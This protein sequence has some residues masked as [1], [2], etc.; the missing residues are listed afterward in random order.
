MND[1]HSGKKNVLVMLGL[2]ILIAVLAASVCLIFAGL[3]TMV[4]QREPSLFTV[5]NNENGQP[6]PYGMRLLT[7]EDQQAQDIQNWLER[8]RKMAGDRVDNEND[9]FWL[10]RQD[11]DEYV[12][13]LPDQDRALTVADVTAAE[14]T[15]EDGVVILVLR[16][17]TPEGGDEIA[18]E[19][20][21]LCFQTESKNWN[22]IRIQVILDG[23]ERQV[24][25]L[26]A[27]G[28]QIYSTEELYIGR[29]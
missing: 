11:T 7:E 18:P 24:Y 8:V 23:R 3:E 6:S 5:L 28:E 25:K 4:P 2:V 17:R 1:T 14:E 9:V 16:A 12:L 10:Y 13:Y 22:G 20:Q 15:A 29:D 26:A 21:L 27:K 19:Q